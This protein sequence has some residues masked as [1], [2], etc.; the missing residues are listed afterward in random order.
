MA[1]IIDQIR[2][3]RPAG[4]QQ[5]IIEALQ[6]YYGDLIRAAPAAWRGRFRKMAAT[7]YA[8]YRGSVGLFYADLGRDDPDPF[9]DA[10]TSRVW[11]HGDM[12]A[13]NYG[14]YMNSQGILV[15]DVNDFDE[16]YVGPYTWDIRRLVASLALL[17]YEKALSDAEIRAMITT[18]VRGYIDQVAR[19]A[20]AP[21]TA[22][23][24]LTLANLR[25]KLLELL[26]SQR[27]RTRW[28]LLAEYSTVQ[29]YE[30]RFTI[31]GR[32]HPIDDATRARVLA[33]FEDYLTS[34]PPG[35]RL[36]RVSYNVKDVVERRDAGLGSAGL[37]MY[38][39]LV[40]GHTQAL[41]NDI[42]LVMKQASTAA[43]SRVITDPRISGYF[44][45]N[46]HRTVISQRALQAYADPWLGYTS[47]D[48][49]G[50]VV[51]DRPPHEADLSWDNINELDDILEVLG[52]LG[53][54]TAKIHCVSDE[55]SDQTLVP[56]STDRAIHVM[57]AGREDAF[58]QAMIAFGEG[59]GAIV[60]DD[61]R[62]FVD[63]FR[64][65]MIPGV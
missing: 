56:F 39:L 29:N 24:A 25:G 13:A 49:V 7:P 3:E 6:T 8:F 42:V 35:K 48:G 1:P 20:A 65:G 28:A 41:E 51:A 2:A 37:T 36:N 54:A 40:E 38:N 18:W 46:G 50:Q 30:R 47:L 4:R 11:I 5:F 16:A 14:T 59:Y 12:H 58:V 63:A 62:L 27:V 34:I 53:Q 23:F 32:L 19:F 21:H 9:T 15:F 60:R 22:T 43:V 33:A 31:G 45:H 17:G 55:D 64:N 61:Y 26:Q 52:F 10:Q 57:L 44:Q